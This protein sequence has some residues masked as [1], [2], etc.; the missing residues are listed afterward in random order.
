MLRRLVDVSLE[1][2][3][4]VLMAA[5]LM[6]TA[7][8]ESSAAVSWLKAV[9]WMGE[10]VE[11]LFRLFPYAAMWVAFTS[12]Y[13]F[14]PNTKV[15]FMAA[16]GGGMVAGTA[17][18]LGQWLYVG[19]NVLLARYS[20]IYSTF[21]SFPVFLIWLYVSWMITLFGAEV[22]FA[23]QHERTYR[24]EGRS[25]DLAPAERERRTLEL[26]GGVANRFRRGEPAWNVDQAADALDIPV[27][28]VNE[29]GAR[30]EAAGIFTA[31]PGPVLSYVPGR[32]LEAITLKQVLDAVRH[33]GAKGPGR[34]GPAAA[35]MESAEAALAERLSGATLDEFAKGLPAPRA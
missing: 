29:L 18:Q 4:L 2:R 19:G 22:A 25:V 20:P 23:L 31:V 1:N 5:A 3:P 6:M 13:L 16:L 26:A 24:R 30:L 9:P 11:I 32:A 7:T 12:F 8:L 17:W 28:L 21:A 14:M 15:P 27:R 34:D 33:G 10:G 35:V